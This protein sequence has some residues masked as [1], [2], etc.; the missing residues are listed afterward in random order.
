MTAEDATPASGSPSRQPGRTSPARDE[1]SAGRGRRHSGRRRADSRTRAGSARPARRWTGGT[2]SYIGFLGGIGVLL[3]YAAF[4][5]LRNAASILVLIF[6]AMFLA[7]GLNPAVT[8]LAQLGPAPR[9]RR[10]RWSR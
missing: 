8:R 3:A 5:G 4:L 1:P 2:R 10:R 6:V 9:R 7:I